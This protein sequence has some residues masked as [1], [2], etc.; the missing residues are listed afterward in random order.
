MHNRCVN[1]DWLEVFCNETS[2][3]LNA[4]YFV[5]KGYKVVMRNYGTP[6][7]REMFTIWDDGQPF[8]EVRRDPYSL[9]EVGGIFRRGD[10]HLRLVNKA[11]YSLSPIDDLRKFLIA[12]GYTYN[13]L[14]RIDIC[15][16]FNFFDNGQRP[17]RVL[18]DYMCGKISKINQ[19][20]IAAHG[21]DSFGGR[22]WHSLSWGSPSSTIRTKLYCKSLEMRE[23]HE[24]PYI[25][26]Q[27][28][29][30]GLDLDRDVWRIEF[31]IKSDLKHLV[32]LDTGELIK[33]DLSCYDDRHKC[34]F[35]FLSF[36]SIYFHFKTLV[37]TKNGT[38]QRKDRC[39]DKILFRTSADERSY[40]PIRCTTKHDL[41]R[42]DRILI[43][44]LYDIY[45]DYNNSVSVRQ[46]AHTLIV[47]LTQGLHAHKFRDIAND[48]IL[49]YDD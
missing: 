32:K 14:S 7:Y 37:Y 44:K 16:D 49:G 1:I 29:A 4:D 31:S 33:H 5:S 19:C 25:L 48:L 47:E 9:R 17:D 46:S 45:H 2:N 6:Q 23:V 22:T 28:L 12:H 40:K 36:A 18:E 27:W 34:L 13:A 11:C 41:T 42:T 3:L 24:K 38:P 30:A 39:P 43:N 15:L 21:K 35:A 26:D 10:C 20:N 8:I